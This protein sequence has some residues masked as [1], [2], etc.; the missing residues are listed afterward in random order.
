MI[1]IKKP[2][3]WQKNRQIN[4]W[5]RIE[6]TQNW[7]TQ[8]HSFELWQN[9]RQINEEKIVFSANAVGTT[10][11]SH[12]KK[13]WIYTS[14]FSQKLIQNGYRFKCKYKILIT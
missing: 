11:H 7:P 3:Y 4:Q 10:G 5:N 13:N 9:E 2:C 1:V 14:H 8:I 6:S 12:T